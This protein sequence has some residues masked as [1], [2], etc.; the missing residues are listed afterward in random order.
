M[1]EEEIIE[2]VQESADEKTLIPTKTYLKAGVHIGAK[3]KTSGM[4]KYVFKKRPDRLK[5]L[6][7]NIIDERLR[8]AAN[9]VANTD[10]GRIV[11]VSR[12]QYG[13]TPVK[14]FSDIIGAHALTGRFIPGTFTNPTIKGFIEPALV[15][16]T[17]PSS[18][19]QA[20]QEATNIRVPVI[21]LCSTDNM[22]DNIDVIIPIN[23][24]G[25]QSLAVAY[26]LLAREVLKIKKIIK[27]DDEFKEKIEEFEFPLDEVKVQEREERPSFQSYRR[28]RDPRLDRRRRNKR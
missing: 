6:D 11:V 27:R 5:V 13:Q 14:K 15:I 3:Y 25:R 28:E 10:S 18:D 8:A 24:K 1:M 7:V 23:N 4:R 16:I 17:D 19:M 21:A 22:T 26:W 20:I 2:S 12:K 9:F